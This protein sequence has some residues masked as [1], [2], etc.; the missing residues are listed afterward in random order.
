V[1]ILRLEPNDPSYPPQVLDLD[2]PPVLTTTGPI[3]RVRGVAIVGSR[4]PMREAEMYA[5]DLARAVASAGFTVLSGGARGIDG[6]AHRGALDVGG[7]TWVVC[8]SGRNHVAP[9]EHAGL[10]EDVAA[11]EGCGLIWPFP[12][13]YQAG[14][15][16]YLL[17][18]RVLVALAE[19][20]VVVQA[21]YSS[22][23]LNAANTALGL[24]RRVWVVGA[25]PWG[26]W[27][28]AFGGSRE[29]LATKPRAALLAG[30]TELLEE[31]GMRSKLSRSRRKTKSM[32]LLLPPAP[33]PDD[34]WSEDEKRVFSAI[35]A[36]PSHRDEVLSRAD[37]G[38]G[39]AAT[40]LLTLVM[41]DVVV[42]G[43]EGFFR[44][45]MAG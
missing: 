11:T 36:A 45:K 26:T 22:G 39:P 28:H 2:T 17:R 5:R 12:D 8:P 19:A 40:A 13:H 3:P 18:N 16:R 23:S 41:R 44:R 10:F 9:P 34:S 30:T 4:T 6:A 25:P 38:A 31:L 24:G 1:N 29:L 35:S 14:G 33:V 15:N 20:V 27:R 42:E 21:R 43:P 32:P 37:L 7:S